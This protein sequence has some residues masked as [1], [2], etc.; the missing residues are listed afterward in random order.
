M[1]TEVIYNE[2]GIG[3][4]KCKTPNYNFNIPYF[5]IATW[6]DYIEENFRSIDALIHYIFEI[7]KYKGK[8]ENNTLYKEE[9]V[10]FIADE[11]SQYNGRIVKI[12]EEHIT[13]DKPFDEFYLEN[14][15]KYEIFADPNYAYLY[16]NEA[17]AAKNSAIIAKDEAINAKNELTS[18]LFT[19]YFTKDEIN[20][21]NNENLL[22]INTKFSE[23][24]TEFNNILT[25]IETTLSEV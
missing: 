17:E 23:I 4:L 7:K 25:E 2:T 18:E 9:E 1:S 11:N 10:V 20:F 16:A 5:D 15:S 13:S 8:W 14:S 21:I 12:L 6:H 3:D 22:Q 24:E 19:N